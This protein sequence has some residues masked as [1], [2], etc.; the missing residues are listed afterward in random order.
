LRLAW[1]HAVLEEA[2]GGEKLGVEE[3][4]AGSATHEIV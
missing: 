3:S 1:G 2:A 4:A